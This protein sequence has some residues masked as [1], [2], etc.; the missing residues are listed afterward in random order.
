MERS[1]KARELSG[2]DQEKPGNYQGKIRKSQ[3]TTRGKSIQLTLTNG[4]NTW[5]DSSS[6]PASLYVIIA[7]AT[8]TCSTLALLVKY[9]K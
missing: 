3:G 5:V 7:S 4:M 2:K 9:L 8:G 6:H 1:G